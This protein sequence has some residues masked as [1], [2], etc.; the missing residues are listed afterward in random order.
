[1]T[2]EEYTERAIKFAEDTKEWSHLKNFEGYSYV[3][4]LW[5]DWEE[6]SDNAHGG[7]NLEWAFHEDDSFIKEHAAEYFIEKLLDEI[8]FG[9]DNEWNYEGFQATIDKYR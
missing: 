1:M 3:T 7:I 9:V 4:G 6:T 2:L 5:E 8:Q